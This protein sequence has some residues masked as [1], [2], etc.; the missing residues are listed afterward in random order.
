MTSFWHQL[1]KPF[2][3]LAPMEAVTDVIFRH[4]V[5]KAGAPDVFFTEFVST[6]GYCSPKGKHSTASRLAFTND[7]Q[8]MVVQSWGD[9]P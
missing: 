1:P 3:I 2:F 9:K 8:P 6:D 7:E 4:V 5:A